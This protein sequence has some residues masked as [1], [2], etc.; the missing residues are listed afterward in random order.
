[1]TAIVIL[2]EPLLPWGWV[3]AMLVYPAGQVILT[4]ILH[5]VEGLERLI[6]SYI[7]NLLDST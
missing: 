1:M 4:E 2:I 7:E 5:C 6:K 3:T